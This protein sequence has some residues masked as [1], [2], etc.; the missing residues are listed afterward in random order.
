MTYIWHRHHHVCCKKNELGFGQKKLLTIRSTGIAGQWG[1]WC[2]ILNKAQLLSPKTNAEKKVGPGRLS[3][4]V[5]HICRWRRFGLGQTFHGNNDFLLQKIIPDLS[6]EDIIFFQ[7]ELE[8][9]FLIRSR[10]LSYSFSIERKFFFYLC[11]RVNNGCRCKTLGMA[12][13]FTINI[14]KQVAVKEE[15]RK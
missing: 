9:F 8:E 5:K 3:F 10:K 6:F 11:F 14:Y 12:W 1:R 7:I 4:Y 15:R 2:R 13:L